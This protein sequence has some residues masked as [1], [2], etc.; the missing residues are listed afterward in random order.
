MPKPPTASDKTLGMDRDIPRRDFL[1]GAA[2]AIGGAALASALPAWAQT[3]GAQPASQDAPGYYPPTRTGMR[4]S[5]PGSFEGAHALRDGKA[6]PPPRATGE[7]YD[8]VI[9]GGGISGLSA[10][11]FWRQQ[12]PDATILILDNHDDFGGHAKRNEFQ[13]DGKTLLLNGGTLEIDSPRPYSDVADGLI[14]AL[15]IDPPALE[16]ADSPDTF[17]KLGLRQGVFFDRE[18][19]GRDKLVVAAPRAG[20]RGKADPEA[21]AQ[22]LAEAPLSEAV[23][24]DIVRIETS[25]TDYLPDLSAEQKMD[26]LSRISYREYL[27][28]VVKA[29]P[30][31]IPY[32]QTRTHGEWGI[33]IDGEPALDCWGLG[34]PGFE[35]LGLDH[36]KTPRMG[37]TAAGYSSTGGSYRYHFPD[38]N[39]S[40]A[41]M[42]V[43]QLVPAA[44]PGSTPQDIITA[45][46]DYAALD[47]PGAPARIRLGS[48]VVHARNQDDGVEVVYEHGG[49]THGVRGKACIMAGYNMMI[50]YIVP[51]LPAEQKAALHQLVKV[52]LVYVSVALRNWR[53]FQTLGVSGASCPGAYFSSF[54]LA[55]AQAVGGYATAATPDEPILVRLTR[56]P[57]LPGAA[58]E[59]DQHRAG[60]AELLATPFEVFERNIR[61]QLYRALGPGGFDPARDIAGIMVNRWPHGYAYEYNPL[62]DPWDIPEDQ[63]PHVIG[64][65]RFGRIAIANSDSGAQAYTSC[66]IDQAHRAVGEL[67][68]A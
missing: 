15:G 50:P 36:A 31:V 26:R 22:M 56:T 67:L 58:T 63:R 11:W 64:R 30:G 34:L 33:G 45:K 46:F 39:A 40:I 20:R 49:A 19:F 10:A 37:Y 23:R 59:R 68:Q 4:G 35:G 60:R 6:P 18:T 52:P 51:D 48:I 47:R 65:Q 8:L 7:A 24:T 25:E 62:Y 43:R 21:L 53:A 66:A 16:K 14:K 57:C 1:Q 12:R 55:P 44:A 38:G 5:H 17:R 41:R 42:L 28:T 61:D 27:L 13:V 2:T 32:Y 29:D 54:G 9:V 3:A